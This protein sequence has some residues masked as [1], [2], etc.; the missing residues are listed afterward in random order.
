MKKYN[1]GFTLVD[2]LISISIISITAIMVSI[3]LNLYFN[4]FENIKIIDNINFT[5]RNEIALM[6]KDI[7]ENKNLGDIKV[8]YYIEDNFNFYEKDVKVINLKITNIKKDIKKEY[9]IYSYDK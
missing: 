9:K 2:V 4:Y 1:R 7:Y 5:A 6:Q 3:L 8:E